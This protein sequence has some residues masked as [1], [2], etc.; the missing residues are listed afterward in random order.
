[1]KYSRPVVLAAQ[2]LFVLAAFL[3]SPT[4]TLFAGERGLELLP[5]PDLPISQLGEYRAA[6]EDMEALLKKN[7]LK[8]FYIE[9]GKLLRENQKQRRTESREWSKSHEEATAIECACRLVIMAPLI[10][11]E[12]FLAQAASGSKKI[13]ECEDL[14]LKSLVFRILHHASYPP[15]ANTFAAYR[16]RNNTSTNP[17]I[18]PKLTSEL[19]IRHAT[20]LAVLTKAINE[21]RTQA[22]EALGK[23][24]FTRDPTYVMPKRPPLSTFIR[25]DFTVDHEA[26]KKSDE[27]YQE[28]LRNNPDPG[29]TR[30][31]TLSGR[32][33]STIQLRSEI[34]TT[35]LNHLVR[36]FPRD[37]ASVQ[38]YL[39]MAGY[40]SDEACA[41]LIASVFP[42]TKETAYL[43]EGLKL[44]AAKK[45]EK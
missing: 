15:H 3:P 5:V 34:G 38:K 12:D 35:L 39:R 37:G 18:F 44:E 42:K 4:T 17:E 41:T 1:M 16:R 22:R 29:E 45:N 7:D 43:Y 23:L 10:P 30:Y 24:K 11:N 36:T 19:Q 21:A 20:Y 26:W 31:R 9:I 25:P 6:I 28:E 33:Q 14:D 13:S 32:Y 2:I 27:K 8:K 40:A